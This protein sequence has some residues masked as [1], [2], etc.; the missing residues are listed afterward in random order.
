MGISYTM[1]YVIFR[2]KEAKKKAHKAIMEGKL[3]NKVTCKE[4]FHP[5]EEICILSDESIP[6]LDELGIEHDVITTE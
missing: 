2:T 3:G 6:V 5:R 4:E 1:K